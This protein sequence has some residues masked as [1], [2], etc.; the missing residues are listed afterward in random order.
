MARFEHYAECLGCSN[1]DEVVQQFIAS[2]RET[3]RTFEYYVDWDKVTR[4]IQE[5]IPELSILNG[6]LRCA[7]DELEQRFRDIIRKYPEVLAV[8]PLLIAER[9]QTLRILEHLDAPVLEV[10]IYDFTPRQLRPI[11]VEHLSL[12]HI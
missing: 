11:D 7:D 6:L 9:A 1:V 12:I 10:L 4:N 5:R 3:N 8:L 2:L